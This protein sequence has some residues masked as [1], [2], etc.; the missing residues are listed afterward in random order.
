MHLAVRRTVWVLALTV[1]PPVLP[2]GPGAQA[3]DPVAVAEREAAA[4]RTEVA[5]TADALTEGTRRIDAARIELSGVQTRLA[6][7]RRDQAAADAASETARARLSAVAAKA[8][9]SPLPDGVLLALSGGPD[10][11]REALVAQA[12]LDRVRGTQ[13]DLVRQASAERVRLQTA[14]RGVEQLSAQAAQRSRDLDAQLD[15]LKATAATADR[16]LSAANARLTAT[17][18]AVQP[19][20]RGTA[21][22][23]RCTGASTRGD[24]NGFL[25][26]AALCPLDG[27]PGAAL[28]ADAA[29]AFN[30]MTAA[31]RAD[32]GTALCVTDSYRPYAGQVA[33]FRR[34]PALAAVPGTS[35]HGLGTAVDLGC[36]AQRFGSAAYRWLKANGPRFGFVH[37]G[38]AEPRG[39][40]PEPWHWEFVG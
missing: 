9:R 24:A 3:A 13:A 20:Y 17:R 32:R 4:M 23:A 37:P 6:R 7:A 5:R 8:Y 15:R 33:V 11:V 22:A 40:T 12:D 28:R 16:Q 18:R 31:A 35:R 10:R 2:L 39:A 14:T 19:R 26:P 29:A 38:W 1:A 30:R 27:A 25:D 34:T 21:V 36:G